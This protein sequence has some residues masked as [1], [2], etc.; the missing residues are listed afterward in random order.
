[1]T[2]NLVAELSQSATGMSLILVS[3]IRSIDEREREMRT[4]QADHVVELVVF[5]LRDGVTRD[6]FLGTVAAASDWIRTQPGFVAD[7]LYSA[8]EDRWI[9]IVR[10]KTLGDAEAAARAAENDPACAPMFALIDTAD[11]VFLHG[12][13]VT[14]RVGAHGGP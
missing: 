7:Q 6:E 11:Q 8:G 5:G 14:T 3:M 2:G 9:E 13:P 1:M 12:L 4:E 10:W